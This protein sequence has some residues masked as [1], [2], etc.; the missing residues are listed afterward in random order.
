MQHADFFPVRLSVR[1]VRAI[2]SANQVFKLLPQ[3]T[4]VECYC[5]IPFGV[6]HVHIRRSSCQNNRLAGA[7]YSSD[8]QRC[9]CKFVCGTVL[10]F[11]HVFDCSVNVSHFSA[12]RNDV[13]F[14]YV[15]IFNRRSEPRDSLQCG[16]NFF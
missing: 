16:T 13:V 1:I 8:T 14:A 15:V 12:E 5:D 6:E 10:K 4:R 9:F 3:R 7:D 11:V 2:K